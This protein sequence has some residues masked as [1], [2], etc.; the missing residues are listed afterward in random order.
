MTL[1]NEK[2]AEICEVDP[3]YT[4][5]RKAWALTGFN[6][7]LTQR[8]AF[9]LLDAIDAPFKHDVVL[10]PIFDLIDYNETRMNRALRNNKWYLTFKFFFGDDLTPN[11]VRH[12]HL[13]TFSHT[14]E[15]GFIDNLS[16][17]P[18][19]RH[20]TRMEVTFHI[21]EYGVSSKP[22]YFKLN[23]SK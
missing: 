7:D 5:L 16:I 11:E 21:E 3:L 12:V 18:K 6:K 4:A 1:L 13:A 23:P 22:F 2:H 19:H 9:H 14:P 15:S 8:L 20:C 17:M 10:M